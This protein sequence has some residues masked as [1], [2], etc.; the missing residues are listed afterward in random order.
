M[1]Y[2]TFLL[3][4]KIYFSVCVFIVGICIG[5]FL[6]VLIYRIPLGMD[7]KKGSSICTTCKHPLKWY[8]LFPLFS[9]IFLGGKCRYCKA[10]I[11]PIYPIVEATNGILWVLAY[12]FLTDCKLNFALFGYFLVC[13]ALVVVFCIDF[14]FQ[15]IP[16]SMWICVLL[17]GVLVYVQQLVE[18]GFVWQ[19]LVSRL[20]GIFTASGV[21]LVLG[22]LYRGGM[23]GGD[24][25]LMAAA[26]FLLGWR[27]VLIALMF[28]A[29]LG[30][31]WLGVTRSLKK[32]DMKKEVPF[33]PHLAIG[34]LL[35]AYFANPLM[36]WYVGIWS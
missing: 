33:G 29:V 4:M 12:I 3:V 23:G 8:D 16:D 26:G 2:E 32:S 14:K 5:S 17:G 36:N 10:K 30:T 19:E 35:A 21:L 28:G 25:K 18:H 15:I 22:M 34:I 31:L 9:W 7:F 20:V 11:S 24:I 13:S 6:N 1:E 27:N